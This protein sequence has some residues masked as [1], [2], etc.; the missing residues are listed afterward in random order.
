MYKLIIIV[1][2]LIS[3]STDIGVIE[4]P[5]GE[6][7]ELELIRFVKDYNVSTSFKYAPKCNECAFL[8]EGQT[9]RYKVFQK[10]S[11]IRDNSFDNRGE[12]GC[13]VDCQSNFILSFSTNFFTKD[14]AYELIVSYTLPDTE[15]FDATVIRNRFEFTY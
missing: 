10:D 5:K 13:Y 7:P 9:I 2:T 14:L 1:L 11:L 12:F 4:E 3:C 6:A 8:V 15:C